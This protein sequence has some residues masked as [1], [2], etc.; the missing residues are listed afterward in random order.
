MQQRRRLDRA[1]VMIASLTFL[2]APR[3]P[4]AAAAEPEPPP[5]ASDLLPGAEEGFVD[6]GGVQSTT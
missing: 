2:L 5:K 3:N 1:L 6:S 4:P